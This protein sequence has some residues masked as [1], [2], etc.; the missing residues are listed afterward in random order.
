M[1]SSIR[2][3][4]DT[5]KEDYHGTPQANAIVDVPH[6]VLKQSKRLKRQAAE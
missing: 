5:A 1:K 4:Q 2:N 6:R 3:G